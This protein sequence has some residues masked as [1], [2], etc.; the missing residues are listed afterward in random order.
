MHLELETLAHALGQLARAQCRLRRQPLPQ[1]VQQFRPELVRR[2]GAALA[3]QQPLQPLGLKVRLRLIERR[4]GQAKFAC[5]PRQGLV[6]VLKCPQ[7]F[8]LELEQVL[9]VE[10]LRVLE[11]P[12][13]D[14]GMTGVESAGGLEGLPFAGWSGCGGHKCKCNYAVVCLVW[15]GSQGPYLVLEHNEWYHYEQTREPHKR[16]SG[17][18]TLTHAA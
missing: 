1:L 15:P 9:R 10:K 2:F 18:I 4:P 5:R 3:G 12:V 11:E 8:I 13:A 16:R 6:F 7:T 17:I 14:T